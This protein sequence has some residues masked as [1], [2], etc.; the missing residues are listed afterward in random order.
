MGGRI[1]RVHCAWLSK[2]VDGGE[3]VAREDPAGERHFILEGGMQQGGGWW[4]NG[5]ERVGGERKPLKNLS[6]IPLVPMQQRPCHKAG[7]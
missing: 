5:G 7:Q 6:P 4:R 2:V 3:I 1:G